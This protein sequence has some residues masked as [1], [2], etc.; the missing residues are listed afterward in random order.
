MAKQNLPSVE[1]GDE[2]RRTQMKPG[3]EIVSQPGTIITAVPASEG[4]IPRSVDAK[5]NRDQGIAL[6]LKLR[7]LEDSGAKTMDGKHVTKKNH[8]VRWLLEQLIRKT[9]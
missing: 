8:V 2:P 5:L 7:E 4:Y 6:K 1:G 3:Q 9:V